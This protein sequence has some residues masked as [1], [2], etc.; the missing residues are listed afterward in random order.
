MLWNLCC[1]CGYYIEVY[2]EFGFEESGISGCVFCL[3][4]V[5]RKTMKILIYHI[6]L[7]CQ[8]SSI[9]DFLMLTVIKWH[10]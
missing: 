8:T 7:L 6:S 2:V 1:L 3:L 5:L 9:T 10:V 4:V